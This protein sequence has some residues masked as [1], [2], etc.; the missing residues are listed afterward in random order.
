LI[1]YMVP[2]P[3]APDDFEVIFSNSK[4]AHGGKYIVWVASKSDGSAALCYNCIEVTVEGG[5]DP[6]VVTITTP[7]TDPYETTERFTTVAGTVTNADGSPFSG[8]TAKIDV[9]GDE[10]T[11]PVDAGTFTNVVVLNVGD[12]FVKVSAENEDGIGVD[13]VNIKCTALSA[14]LWVRL[15][16]DKDYSDIDMYITEPSGETCWYAHKKSTGTKAEIDVDDVDGYGPEH[17]YLSTA[18]GHT[19]LPGVYQIDVQYYY[20]HNQ[21]EPNLATIL[22]YKAD[23]YY[24]EWSHIMAYDSPQDAGPQHRRTGL[25]T[26]WDNVANISMP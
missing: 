15:T 26:W 20:F 9:N 7:D 24:G 25:R 23:E 1:M 11:I 16:W 14:N 3:E 5:L 21:T 17:Y 6:P 2:N 19:L 12:N 13:S 10:Q 4:L 18:E 8:T 22:V